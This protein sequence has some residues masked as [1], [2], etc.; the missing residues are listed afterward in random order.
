VDLYECIA[1]VCMSV[2][3]AH[4]TCVVDAFGVYGEGEE[5]C[6]KKGCMEKRG[7]WRRGVYGEEGC[8]EKSGVCM[9]VV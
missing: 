8:M 1:H 9:R 3:H 2:L 7:V 4:T 6:M 5:G